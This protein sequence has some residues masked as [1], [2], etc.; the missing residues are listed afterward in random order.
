M[1]VPAFIGHLHPLVVHLPIGILLFAALLMVLQQ[2]GVTNLDTAISLAWSLG[3]VSALL[4][5]GAGW[6]LAQSGE[7]DTE[8]V[9][10]HQWTGL[11]TAG[12]S[13][14]TY[15]TKRYRWMPA[16]A[17]LVFLTVAGHY[18]GTLT[19]GD[20]YLF[21]HSKP[22]ASASP[23]DRAVQVSTSAM[24]PGDAASRA[25]PLV[26]RTFLY[27]DQVVPI[28][29]SHC[30]SCH[31]ARK[32]KGGLRLDSEA[33]IRQGGKNGAVLTA[34]NPAR[35]KLFTYL[36]LPD[37]D[38]RHMPPKGK[39]QPTPQAIATIHFWIQQGAS[40]REKVD[41]LA[42]SITPQT[43]TAT[44]VIPALPRSVRPD[45]TVT[46][47]QP[48]DPETALLQKPVEAPA[49]AILEKLKQQQVVLTQLVTDSHYY[50]ANFVNV[51]EY[52]PALLRNLGELRQQVVRLR[53][54]NQPV[55]DTDIKQLT[56]FRNLTRLNLEHTHIT[57]QA[58]SY[59]TELPNL[60]QLNLYGTA[61]TDTGLM[62]LAKCPHL[63]RLYLWQTQTTPAGIDRLRKAR[64]TLI[65]ETGTSRLVKPDTSQPL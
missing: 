8:L 40:F 10:I 15:F 56:S 46:A 4:A 2:S 18:G 5:C 3:A 38:D 23:P 43:L 19:H 54:T 49:P 29:E 6:L 61:I 47:P 59:L 27:R 48:P 52:Q 58:L 17:T 39:R 30:Y 63:K 62:E 26:R 51:A 60:E 44:D 57:D 24:E 64:P 28:L 7:Y 13:T 37:G 45:T 41:T 36:L 9:T 1:E 16:V 32:K 21:A 33:F 11:G 22:E 65:I 14:L 31:S 53:L 34:G 25:Q 50:S 35:S 42:P 20:D 12:L 55:G